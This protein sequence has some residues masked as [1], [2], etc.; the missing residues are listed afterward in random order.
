MLHAELRCTTV[1][2][3]PHLCLFTLHPA[4]QPPAQLSPTFTRNISNGHRVAGALA[5]RNQN[6][7]PAGLGPA[8]QRAGPTRW[9]HT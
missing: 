1:G 3:Q 5:E 4:Q 2:E 8:S 6:L 9:S 7:A